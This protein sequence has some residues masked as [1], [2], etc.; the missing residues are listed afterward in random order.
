MTDTSTADLTIVRIDLSDEGHVRALLALLDEYA[1]GHTGTGHGL[2]A[3]VIERLPSALAERP[4]FVGWL[5]IADGRPAGVV[6][7]FEGLSTFRAQPLLNIHDIAVAEPYRR[8]GIGGALLL[9]VEQEARQRGCCK[10]TLEVLSNNGAAI[11]AYRQAGFKPYGLNPK[12][13]SALFF[14]KKFY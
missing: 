10:I 6:T 3:D 1:R 8:R 4:W 2:A 13:G 9:Q 14:E 5:A 7:C 11:A 12:M